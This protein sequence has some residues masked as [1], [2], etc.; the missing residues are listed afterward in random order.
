MGNFLACRLQ[1]AFN[2]FRRV[3]VAV[4]KAPR[5]LRKRRRQDEH[6]DRFRKPLAHLLMSLHIDI[7]QDVLARFLSGLQLLVR[8]AV[9]CP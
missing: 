9:R 6:A 5:Q 3:R 2:L 7:E 4:A 8:R 1:P